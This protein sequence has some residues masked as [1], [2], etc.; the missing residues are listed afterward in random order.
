VPTKPGVTFGASAGFLVL[1]FFQGQQQA[2]YDMNETGFPDQ[3]TL[4]DKT[5]LADLRSLRFVGKGVFYV[6]SSNPHAVSF[7][8]SEAFDSIQPAVKAVGGPSH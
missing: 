5:V 2:D 6:T 3:L 1:M 7:Y 8:K 4:K